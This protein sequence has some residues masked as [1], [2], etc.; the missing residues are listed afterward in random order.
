MSIYA[1]GFTD[2]VVVLEG[3]KY[4]VSKIDVIDV[5]EQENKPDGT[6][7][8]THVIYGFEILVYLVIDNEDSSFVFG[9][10]VG[11]N[12]PLLVSVLDESIIDKATEVL[13]TLEDKN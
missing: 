4:K 2:A 7:Q 13:W 8:I 9:T 11:E 6:L 12:I 3:E 5:S 10:F 1:E